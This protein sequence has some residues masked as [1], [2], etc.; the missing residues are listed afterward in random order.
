MQGIVG[1]LD[2]P[3]IHNNVGKTDSRKVVLRHPSIQ[4]LCKFVRLTVG[5]IITF[6]LPQY[7]TQAL[8]IGIN[9]LWLVEL[10]VH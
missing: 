3:Y 4:L 9:I 6:S 1:V 2:S 10:N 7:L 8:H 5:F